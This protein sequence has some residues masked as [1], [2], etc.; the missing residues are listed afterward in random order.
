MDFKV[1]INR[2]SDKKICIYIEDNA[3][4]IKFVEAIMNP[5]EFANAV[6]GLAYQ[7]A[8]GNVK[9]LE[10]V[11]K[12]RI[13]EDRSVECPLDTYDKEKLQ[14]WLKENCQEDDWL[15]DTYLGSQSSVSWKNG[16]TILNYAVIKYVEVE[17]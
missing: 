14:A 2:R 3:S 15:L 13:R 1:S 12:K 6:T 5:E 4:G 10:Y 9:G 8:T 11:G 7:E 17:E 16:K